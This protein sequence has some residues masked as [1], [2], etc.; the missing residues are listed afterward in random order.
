MFEALWSGSRLVIYDC[1]KG[2]KVAGD[3]K[4]TAGSETTLRLAHSYIRV[5][6]F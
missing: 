5:G 6:C 3:E 1:S 2:E 4:F